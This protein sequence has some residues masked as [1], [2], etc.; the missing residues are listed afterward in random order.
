MA[1]PAADRLFPARLKPGQFVHVPSRRNALRRLAH[2]LQSGITL[3]IG[4]DGA[5]KTA[6]AI[7]LLRELADR[8]TPIYLPDA[9]FQSPAELHQAILF[10]L[11]EPFEGKSPPELRFAVQRALVD[12]ALGKPAI[13]ALDD[14]HGLGTPVLEEL[15]GLSNI[16]AT[17]V[18]LI[19]TAS[20][21][22]RLAR[23]A[24][25]VVQSRL[26]GCIR[27]G[28]FTAEDACDF[29]HARLAEQNAEGAF[30]DEAVELLAELKSPAAIVKAASLAIALCEES[31]NDE[32]D[33]EA[34]MAALEPEQSAEPAALKALAM[35]DLP[36][37]VEPAMARSPKQPPRKRKAA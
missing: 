30:T 25:S 10:D 26:N 36:E 34:A 20:L 19:A 2:S 3:L 23:P 11:G 31:G 35:E 27:L 16:A 32:V 17:R 22:E 9:R 13:L 8:A 21:P 37:P 28:D 7:Q 6:L 12:C 4:D 5:G 24:L 18:L 14:A 29:L 1:L 33:A 15:R